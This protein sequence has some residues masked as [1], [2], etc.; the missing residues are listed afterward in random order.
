MTDNEKLIEDAAKAIHEALLA[1]GGYRG[2]AEAALAVFEKAHTPT[3]DEREALWK[4]IDK[5]RRG[6][7]RMGSGDSTVLRDVILASGFRRSEVPE[8]SGKRHAWQ[9]MVP[10]S[11]E[12]SCAE[13]GCGC[14]CHKG[15]PQG[16]PSDAQVEEVKRHMWHEPSKRCGCGARIETLDDQVR[17]VL[18]AAGGVR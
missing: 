8:P 2:G 13:P 17:H 6:W 14:W 11:P 5:E 18:R 12:G 1:K 7:V 9:C 10:Y 3:D 16:E 4:V 15:E